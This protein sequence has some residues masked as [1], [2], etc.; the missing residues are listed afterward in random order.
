ME[1]K[2]NPA[3]RGNIPD[4]NTVQDSVQIFLII[5]AWLDYKHQKNILLA[6]IL[7]VSMIHAP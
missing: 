3:F 7:K 1:E 6:F 2:N 4:I 5:I